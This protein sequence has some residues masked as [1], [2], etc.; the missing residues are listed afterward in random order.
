MAWRKTN[1]QVPYEKCCMLY[2]KNY[3]NSNS[4]MCTSNSYARKNVEPIHHLCT[5]SKHVFLVDDKMANISLD[6]HTFIA[7]NL[8]KCRFHSSPQL[9]WPWLHIPLLSP[10]RTVDGYSRSLR[11]ATGPVDEYSCIPTS[12]QVTCIAASLHTG[13]CTC[14]HICTHALCIIL[15]VYMYTYT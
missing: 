14:V 7:Q 6:G 3:Y 5:M 15:H 1:G 13:A 8:P 12:L 11:D 9:T 2:A 10:L 4:H